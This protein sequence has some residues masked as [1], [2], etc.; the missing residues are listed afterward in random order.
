MSS[1]LLLLP[2]NGLLR[3]HKHL[4]E[5]LKRDGL[6]AGAALRP[7]P[8]AP[9]AVALLDQLERVLFAP[10]GDRLAP[11]APGPWLRPPAAAPDFVFDLTGRT[12]PE[13]D[14]FF[15][16]FGG[17][18]GDDARDLLLLSR[19]APRLGLAR[20]CGEALRLHA[21]ALIALENPHR[22]G[23]GREAFA[24]RLTTLIR[25]LARRGPGEGAATP[26]LP[27]ATPGLAAAASFLRASLAARAR[28]RLTRLVAHDGHWRIA[29][30]RL[31]SPDDGVQSRLDW[32]QGGWTFLE[33]DRRR[34]F[35][36]PFFFEHAGV[37]HVFC[38]EYPYATGKGVI[39]WFPLDAAGRPAAP[40]RVVLERPWHLSYPLVFA[41]D[42]AIWMAPE[43]SGGG[44]FE[45]FRADPF[46][47]RWTLDRIALDKPLADAT[48]FPRDGRFWLTA[49]LAEDGGSSW[50]CLSLFTSASP[51]GPWTPCGD[52]PTLIDAGAA[53][54]AGHVFE[55]DGALWRPAQDCT[56]GYGAGLALCRIDGLDERGLR[57]TAMRRLGPPPGLRA[58]G[59]HTLNAAAGFEIIDVVGARS[60][61]GSKEDR[62]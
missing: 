8:V 19:A 21:D 25:R 3:W 40:P 6:D 31:A 10:C 22:F 49:T 39:S 46:P 5:T 53:R 32:P 61:R 38:E 11:E 26:L 60:K 24:A 30:R 1:V 42:G 57:Q 17:A 15:P 56:G 44:G 7:G 50:D 55:R 12:A 48:I 36:D 20:R 47:N 14:A 58:E 45:L 37:I 2:E 43:G 54:P 41:H 59:V 29:W 9:P 51:L 33:D 23:A 34:Y 18:P 13:L 62:R 28:R 16:I 4:V 27:M 35:A 52:G